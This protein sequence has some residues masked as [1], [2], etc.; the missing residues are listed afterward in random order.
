MRKRAAGLQNVLNYYD[1]HSSLTVSRTCEA[2]AR[3][4][5]HALH[6]LGEHDLV[7]LACGRGGKEGKREDEE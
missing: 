7:D 2:V 1:H 6:T 3:P 4:E 5:I